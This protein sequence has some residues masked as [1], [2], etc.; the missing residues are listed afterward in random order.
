MEGGAFFIG[1]IGVRHSTSGASLITLA[2]SKSCIT[3]LIPSSASGFSGYCL[4]LGLYSDLPVI[5][6]GF[7][8]FNNPTSDGPL[9][10]NFSGTSWSAFN[11][12]SVKH[13]VRESLYH[14]SVM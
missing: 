9:L 6:I 10:H 5:S 3:G 8:V 13:V 11:S 14:V 12:T 7:A 1:N 2:F 4:I